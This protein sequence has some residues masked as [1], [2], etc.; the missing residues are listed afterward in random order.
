FLLR[1]EV[2]LR[3]AP[4]DGEGVVVA[5]L[6]PRTGRYF[7]KLDEFPIGHIGLL[8]AKVIADG[9]RNIES[10]AAVEIRFG[11]LVA[12]DVFPVIVTK[13]TGVLPLRVD[14]SVALADGPQ[15]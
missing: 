13:R 3:C 7:G 10:G 12:E 9:R 1:F 8:Q 2:L 4:V 14:C 6:C 15:A 5:E 11:P